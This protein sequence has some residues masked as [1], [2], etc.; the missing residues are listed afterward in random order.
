MGCQH[1]FPSFQVFPFVQAC[2]APR[3]LS[4]NEI[5]QAFEGTT[6]NCARRC[7]RAWTTRRLVEEIYEGLEFAIYSGR[8][9]QPCFALLVAIKFPDIGHPVLAEPLVI[10]RGVLVVEEGFLP[11]FMPVRSG[12]YDKQ[13]DAETDAWHRLSAEAKQGTPAAR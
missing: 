1:A 5:V 13:S 11:I 10:L 3:P 6:V 8:C 2:S 12:G 4:S 7:L 9:K